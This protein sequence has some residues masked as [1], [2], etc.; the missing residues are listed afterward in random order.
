MKTIINKSKIGVTKVAKKVLPKAVQNKVVSPSA[1]L[2]QQ[3]ND[4]LYNPSQHATDWEQLTLVVRKDKAPL[5][6][7]LKAS[8]QFQVQGKWHD[9]TEE[10]VEIKISF[11]DT[12]N[13]TVGRELMEKLEQY[14]AVAVKE[15][16]L[17]AYTSPIEETSL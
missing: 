11:K 9:V 4:L 12:P 16:K 7:F 3:I 8:T 1:N 17:F 13:E 10:N 2:Q 15:E 6:D 14:N 5:F